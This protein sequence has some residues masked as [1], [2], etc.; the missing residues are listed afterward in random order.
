MRIVTGCLC[1]TP[2]DYLT[3]LAGI[4]LA[5]LLR[6]GGTFSVAYRSLTDSKY[7]IHELMVGP[8]TAH[9]KRLRSRHPYV[10]TERKLRS[11]NYLN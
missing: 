3:I 11:M 2:T 8:I 6:Q 7:L 1:P 9:E 4:Q 10:R 5:E